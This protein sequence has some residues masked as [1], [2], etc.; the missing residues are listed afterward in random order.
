MY[1]HHGSATRSTNHKTYAKCETYMS[2][3][4]VV[5]CDAL[6]IGDSKTAR[7][8][9]IV[10]YTIK[11][12]YKDE[13]CDFSRIRK[14]DVVY[15]R[16]DLKRYDYIN[17]F[18]DK[19]IKCESVNITI[20]CDFLG[21]DHFDL[22]SRLCN[23]SGKIKLV[24]SMSGLVRLGDFKNIDIYYNGAHHMN[25][26]WKNIQ[27]FECKWIKDIHHFTGS[28]L[29]LKC[30]TDSHEHKKHI[31]KIKYYNC[32]SLLR[33]VTCDELSV[34]NKCDS[35]LIAKHH[36]KKIRIAYAT[37]RDLSFITES[38]Y[39]LEINKCTLYND[40]EANVLVDMVMNSNIQ[41]FITTT[42]L[43]V[44]NVKKLCSRSW[45]KLLILNIQDVEFT[46]DKITDCACQELI[47]PAAQSMNIKKYFEW[48]QRSKKL[49]HDK[50]YDGIKNVI[51]PA[52]LINLIME[53]FDNI[54]SVNI[55]PDSELYH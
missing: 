37:I 41:E 17:D 46:Y 25:M 6:Q 16:S 10:Y 4:M 12:H 31:K 33:G 3:Y 52:D 42:P 49:Y 2:K 48:Q 14:I 50:V 20:H 35:E 45:V 53:Y 22:L 5:H 8:D 26:N 13:Q 47:L 36:A 39:S 54:L 19:L 38:V 55:G 40:D 34:I 23:H 24:T 9:M 1:L 43:S 32:G 18:V 29:S 44:A 21:S 15:I 27:S 51:Q 30:E 11:I 28:Y 7:D